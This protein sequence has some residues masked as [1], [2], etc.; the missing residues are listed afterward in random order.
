MYKV[1]E[2]LVKSYNDF[3]KKGVLVLNND[4]NKRVEFD[5]VQHWGGGK[6]L[7]EIEFKNKCTQY[8]EKIDKAMN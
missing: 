1:E 6:N 3:S 8:I 5:L 7:P 4:E 2:A